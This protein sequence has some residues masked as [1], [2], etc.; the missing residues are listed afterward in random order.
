MSF[1][2]VILHALGPAIAAVDPALIHLPLDGEEGL[3]AEVLCKALEIL[4][5]TDIP[6]LNIKTLLMP[7]EPNRTFSRDIWSRIKE[8]QLGI[9]EESAIREESSSLHHQVSIWTADDGRRDAIFKDPAYST[10]GCIELMIRFGP[11]SVGACLRGLLQDQKPSAKPAPL[12]LYVL[13]DLP[14][15][16]QEAMQPEGDIRAARESMR[17][18]ALTENTPT[19]EDCARAMKTVIVQW[20]GT[21]KMSLAQEC[22]SMTGNWATD[23]RFV[24]HTAALLPPEERE[25]FASALLDINSVV[26]WRLSASLSSDHVPAFNKLVELLGKL[27]HGETDSVESTFKE[28]YIPSARWLIDF[29]LDLVDFGDQA[30]G[31]LDL[32]NGLAAVGLLAITQAA[33]T[34]LT[35]RFP[36]VRIFGDELLS[37]AI[38]ME[39][40]VIYE[41]SLGTPEAGARHHGPILY[42]TNLSMEHDELL[43]LPNPDEADEFYCGEFCSDIEALSTR[44]N[45]PDAVAVLEECTGLPWFKLKR[46]LSTSA[47]RA[48]EIVANWV[49]FIV[50]C[51]HSPRVHVRLAGFLELKAVYEIAQAGDNVMNHALEGASERL[52]EA[53]FGEH[54]LPKIFAQIENFVVEK[55]YRQYAYDE[56][57]D[58][59]GHLVRIAIYDYGGCGEQAAK[60]LVRITIVNISILSLNSLL[61]HFKSYV[62]AEETQG[63][64]TT[65]VL[66]W[67]WE[68]KKKKWVMSVQEKNCLLLCDILLTRST[69]NEQETSI[70][71]A[72][73]LTTLKV[74]A[75]AH[76]IFV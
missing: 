1:H 12:L 41:T 9:K 64:A 43:F 20:V 27:K 58:M 47:A 53:M 76:R 33:L 66:R 42:L 24:K 32:D 69:A 34:C 59:M 28:V 11:S 50:A 68:T 18:V 16:L 40:K 17:A 56:N 13:T 15:L 46:M 36:M 57:E 75:A 73:F 22:P 52:V 70:V 67:M 4:F 14:A 60:L 51:L 25:S 71:V 3:A 62:Q 38:S 39:K 19:E 29:G 63:A 48:R 10:V 23:K 26:A 44:P 2:T 7:S 65:L 6:W 37:A 55:Y 30:G 8:F 74:I 45:A 61:G 31:L 54:V 72:S 49:D 5:K 21:M 35:C